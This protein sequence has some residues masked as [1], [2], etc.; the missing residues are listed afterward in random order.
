MLA[1]LVQVRSTQ[2]VVNT[3]DARQL[4]LFALKLFTLQD[5]VLPDFGGRAWPVCFGQVVLVV[6]DSVEV[7]LVLDRADGTHRGLALAVIVLGFV[8]DMPLGHSHF[9]T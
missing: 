6:T 2:H 9:K 7:L 4:L 5:M 3:M 1:V 8:S